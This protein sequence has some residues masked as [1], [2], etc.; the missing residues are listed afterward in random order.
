MIFTKRAVNILRDN[1]QTEF[2]TVT[3]A[4]TIAVVNLTAVPAGEVHLYVAVNLQHT[5]SGA[6]DAWI[7]YED[8]AGNSV[9]LNTAQGLSSGFRRALDRP[10]LVGPGA[11]L[12]GRSRNT[13]NTPNDFI[14]EAHFLRLDPNEYVP[15]APFG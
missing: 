8:P 3:A 2:V 10:Y 4:G 5:D 7:A 1:I 9:A 15:G 6:K 12:I 13:I 11:R 14:I